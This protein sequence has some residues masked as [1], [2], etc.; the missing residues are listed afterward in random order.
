MS[1]QAS[2]Y[3]VKN[4]TLN[5]NNKQKARSIAK[6]LQSASWFYLETFLIKKK[7]QLTMWGSLWSISWK[8]H[9]NPP[10]SSL[11]LWATLSRPGRS[12]DAV[13]SS[14]DVADLH[15]CSKTAGRRKWRRQQRYWEPAVGLAEIAERIERLC[16]LRSV[17]CWKT[18]VG[19]RKASNCHVIDHV[20]AT[21]SLIFIQSFFKWIRWITKSAEKKQRCAMCL[22]LSVAAVQKKVP[23]GFRHCEVRNDVDDLEVD[24]L[25][26]INE[27]FLL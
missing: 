14:E 19:Q 20:I 4:V 26:S 5:R 15:Q 17:D 7:L 27:G 1:D 3:P 21:F 2:P 22:L 13:R 6:E 8:R 18:E 23:A 16:V 10:H 9:P 11:L 25:L 12:L 24:K